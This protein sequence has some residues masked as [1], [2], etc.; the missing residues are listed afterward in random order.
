M[1]DCAPY[2]TTGVN[3]LG[4]TTVRRRAWMAERRAGFCVDPVNP[5]RVKVP[6]AVSSPLTN[7]TA[8]G[9]LKSTTVTAVMV[10][11]PVFRLSVLKVVVPIR[12]TELVVSNT[13]SPNFTLIFDVLLML[14]MNE[15]VRFSLA[16]STVF[17]IKPTNL[18]SGK[19]FSPVKTLLVSKPMP[20]KTFCPRKEPKLIVASTVPLSTTVLDSEVNR[21]VVRETKAPWEVGRMIKG[22]GAMVDDAV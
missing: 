12:P 17:S 10:L 2:A 5:V 13:M 18:M 3:F 6:S 16:G 20:G 1:K 8:P 4:T 14:T 19:P 21:A 15:M 7:S 9:R 11:S 22:T